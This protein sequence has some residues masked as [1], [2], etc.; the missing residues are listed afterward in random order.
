MISAKTLRAALP[1][2][3]TET[4]AEAPVAVKN[5]QLAILRRRSDRSNYGPVYADIA[6]A[7]ADS[8]R[9]GTT[10][11]SSLQ[12]LGTL[13]F[14]QITIKRTERQMTRFPRDCESQRVTRR[15][16]KE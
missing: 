9:R 1:E 15:A 3:E 7:A 16:P 11:P 10:G 2:T 5:K 12:A 14:C 8:A 13:D 6:D 4:G